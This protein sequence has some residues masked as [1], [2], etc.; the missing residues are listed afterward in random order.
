MCAE[1]VNDCVF[2]SFFELFLHFLEREVHDIVVMEFL[3]R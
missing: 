2:L 3:S 1:A